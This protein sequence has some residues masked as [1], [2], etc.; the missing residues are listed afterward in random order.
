MTSTPNGKGNKFY[1]LMTSNTLE[2]VWSRHIVDIY[3]AVRDGLPRDIA[4]MRQALND[5][6]AWAQEFELKW[7]DEASAWL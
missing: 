1:E 5:D 2:N 7:L 6:D 4:Q 3:R